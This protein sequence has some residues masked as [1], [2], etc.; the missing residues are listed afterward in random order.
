MR[1]ID[2]NVLVRLLMKD[3]PAQLARVTTMLRAATACAMPTVILETE[4]VLRSVYRLK[5]GEILFGL[6][7]LLGLAELR[8]EMPEA[9]AQGL[10]WFEQGMDFADALH[11]ATV[12][13]RTGIATF[14]RDFI[15][16]AARLGLTTVAEP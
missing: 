4:W 10:D 15:R 2:T 14:D 11:L 7:G 13:N 6:R 5:P 12:R 9:V 16:T 1:A 3:D 8:I